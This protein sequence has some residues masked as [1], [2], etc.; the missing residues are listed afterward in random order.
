MI[1]LDEPKN[2]THGCVIMASGAGK[3]FG[4]NKLLAKLAGEPLVSYPIRA[5]AGLFSRLVVVTRHADVTDLCHAMG[6]GVIVHGE[7]SRSDVVRIG[8]EAMDGCD[9]VT[10]V[11][12]DQPFIGRDS[13][14][15][16]IAAAEA[17]CESIWRMSFEGVVGAPVLFP[18]WAFGELCSLPSGKGGGFVA[19]AHQDCV[20]CVEAASKWELFDVDTPADLQTVQ[21]VIQNERRPERCIS[22]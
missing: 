10:F 12:G 6:V 5:S 7:P 22:F 4:G 15:S 21:A 18:S 20:R 9:D 13:L 2:C 17:D 19:K 14:K 1:A 16:L 8:I 11:Q 3:R